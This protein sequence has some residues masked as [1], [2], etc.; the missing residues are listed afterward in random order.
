M[1]ATSGRGFALY[2]TAWQACTLGPCTRANHAACSATLPPPGCWP[3]ATVRTDCGMAS[4]PVGTKG[5]SSGV[6]GCG[7]SGACR[8]AST[9]ARQCDNARP[10]CAGS[11]R[12]AHA[13]AN[14]TPS[15]VQPD[16]RTCAGWPARSICR[17]RCSGLHGKLAARPNAGSDTLRQFKAGLQATRDSVAKLKM[18]RY[19][20][21]IISSERPLHRSSRQSNYLPLAAL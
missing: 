15:A 11:A 12:A 19:I 13:S 14:V 6:P 2:T 20:V 8:A 4:A 10:A 9:A 21:P 1:S 7:A 5:W 16:I 17:S 18:N 3:W